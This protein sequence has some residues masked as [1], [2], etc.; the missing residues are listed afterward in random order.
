V[1][2]NLVRAMADTLHTPNLQSKKYVDATQAAFFAVAYALRQTNAGNE[3]GGAATTIRMTA[4]LAQQSKEV[5]NCFT[6]A[7]KALRDSIKASKASPPPNATAPNGAAPNAAA[8]NAPPA[9][10]QPVR[11]TKP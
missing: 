11:A 9:P 4:P 3:L 1:Q 5:R 6:V 10:K 8:P 7:A 2:A